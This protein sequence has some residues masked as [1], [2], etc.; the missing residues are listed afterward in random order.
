MTNYFKR[1]NVSRQFAKR[2]LVQ[3]QDLQHVCRMRSEVFQNDF[4]HVFEEPTPAICLNN[5]HKA[6]PDG[7]PHL[8][9]KKPKDKKDK[10]KKKGYRRSTTRSGLKYNKQ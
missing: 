3:K 2:K 6:Y 5:I 1:A 10:P 4:L 7:I 9:W 8:K